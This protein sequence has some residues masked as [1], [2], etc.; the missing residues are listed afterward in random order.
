MDSEQQHHGVTPTFEIAGEKQVVDGRTIGVVGEGPRF[1]RI[2]HPAA[3]PPFRPTDASLQA[4]GAVMTAQESRKEGDIPAGYTYF[5]QFIDHD[6]TLDDTPGLPENSPLF[7]DPDL[8]KQLRSP[9]LDLDSLYGN[10]QVDPLALLA[11]DGMRLT[12]GRSAGVS[13]GPPFGG[14][15]ADRDFEAADV[16]RVST[17]TDPNEIGKAIIGDPRN[18]ENLIVQQLHLAMLKFHNRVVDLLAVDDPTK[19]TAAVLADAR[20]LVTRHYQWIVIE[21]FL[22][23]LILPDT[24]NAVFGVARL[25]GENFVDPAPLI[26]KI[27]AA[28]TPPM[29]LEFSGAAFRMGHS[30]VRDRY[31]WNRFFAD[32]DFSQFFRFTKLSGNLGGGPRF[33]SN[34]IADWRRMFDFGAVKGFPAIDRAR[35]PLNMAMALDTH[36]ATE[37]GTLPGNPVTN[38]ASRNLVR[39]SRYGLP[40]GQDVAEAIVAAGD[41][42]AAPLDEAALI[43]GLDDEAK[44]ALV[45]FDFHKK[46]P[47]WYYILREAE[48]GG[49]KTLG[50]VGWRILAE[51]FLAMVRASVTSI[52][53]GSVREPRKLALF[54]PEHSPLRTP[55]GE[56]IVSLPHLLHFVGDINPLGDA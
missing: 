19:S 21:D 1:G 15:P 8:P 2:F 48:V 7:D 31:S 17:A 28:Q 10:P 27:S 54:N 39:G 47:L 51:T 9:S 36:L 12:I 38:L 13:I 6:L 40:S 24:F 5:G 41:A 43:D 35:F 4:L 37:L 44:A 23:R 33:P 3:L 42:S 16:P 45:S 29:P 34:W 22:K 20:D 50:P 46:T 56:A 52:F 14:P 30:M 25:T 11:P 26:F 53:T 55:G 32:A 49:G 18:D